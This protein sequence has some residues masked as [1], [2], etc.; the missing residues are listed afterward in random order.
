MLSAL[1]AA[2]VLSAQQQTLPLTDDVWVYQH[3]F[4]Q[5]NDPFL[6]AWG[7]SDKPVTDMGDGFIDGSFSLLK[8]ELGEMKTEGELVGAELVLIMPGP[9]GF[10]NEQAEENPLQARPIES[11]FD[12]E[13]WTYDQAPDFIPNVGPEAVFGT[14]FPADNGQ[15]TMEIRVDLMEG[16]N[17]FV[18]YFNERLESGAPLTFALT[19]MLQPVQAGDGSIYKLYGKAAEESLRPQLVLM[20][21]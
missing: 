20:F 2:G 19:S 4:D 13:N 8:F 6:R 18:A 1:L 10:T 7:S 9:M 3:A 17:D 16:P 11:N 12:E 5:L 15:E 21:E 14:G